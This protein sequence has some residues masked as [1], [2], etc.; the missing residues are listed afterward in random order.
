MDYS[1]TTDNLS[2]P[3]IRALMRN[4]C[5]LRSYQADALRNIY[6]GT[7]SRKGERFAVTFPRQSGKNETQAQLESALMAASLM[8]GGTIIKILLAGLVVI[9]TKRTREGSAATGSKGSC[10]AS[11]RLPPGRSV[12]QKNRP[13]GAAPGYVT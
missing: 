3:V 7:L 9:L 6:K 5:A 13:R 2:D 4:D 11:C 8:R 12:L 1:F 10:G